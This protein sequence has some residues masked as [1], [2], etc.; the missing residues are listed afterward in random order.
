MENPLIHRFTGA[1]DIHYG[2]A[3]TGFLIKAKPGLAIKRGN[4]PDKTPPG[5][6][7]RDNAV[8]VI[9]SA[10]GLHCAPTIRADLGPGL[11]APERLTRQVA[12]RVTLCRRVIGA[13]DYGSFGGQDRQGQATGH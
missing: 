4:T 3:V 1:S 13:Q 11:F 2:V 9:G 10:R 7:H 12:V 8:L 5:E 6:V